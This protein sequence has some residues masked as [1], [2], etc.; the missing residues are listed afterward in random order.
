MSKSKIPMD[1]DRP[2][3]TD[4][5]GVQQA[6]QVGYKQPP[7]HARFQKGK[8]G[9]PNGRSTGHRNVAT[10]LKEMFNAVVAV[11]DGE[12][13]RHI[14]TGEAMIRVLVMKAG[15]GD[16]QAFSCIMRLL[17]MTGRLDEPG[18]E[19]RR[20]FT[21]A[22]EPVRHIEEWKLLYAPDYEQERQRYLA[23]SEGNAIESA[24]SC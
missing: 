6:A 12:K 2:R 13:T 20:K 5:F 4:A 16:V 18:D 19:H 11:R 24:V 1:D 8:S 14:A 22:P 10:L 9:N 3:G 7:A 23:M 17:E 15:K 21:V